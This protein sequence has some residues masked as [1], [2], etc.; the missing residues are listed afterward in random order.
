[1]Y[2]LN[3]RGR[4]DKSGVL[5]GTKC[6]TRGLFNG[7][8]YL[9]GCLLMGLDALRQR[10]WENEVGVSKH[11]TCALPYSNPIFFLTKHLTDKCIITYVISVHPLSS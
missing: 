2:K 8:H 7:V 3:K 5:M 4:L 11:I 6:K 10:Q 9:G 1:M